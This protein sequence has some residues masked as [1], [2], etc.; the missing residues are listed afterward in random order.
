MSISSSLSTVDGDDECIVLSF[1]S[2]A[3]GLDIGLEQVGLSV[4]LCCEN[5]VD[6]AA[7]IRDNK[8]HIP[9]LGDACS[10]DAEQVLHAASIDNSDRVF[11]V[12]G[13]PPCQ[14]FST[15]GKRKALN[16]VR[17]N[18]LLAFVSLAL[19]I[20]PRYVL[21]ENVRGL[22]FA[23]RGLVLQQVADAFE[24]RGYGVAFNLY[25]AANFGVPQRRERVILIASRDGSRVPSLVPTHDE[26]ARYGL[27]R[28]TTFRQCCGEHSDDETD[29]EHVNFSEERLRFFRML[30]SGQNWRSLPTPELQQLALGN[31]NRSS[32]GTTGYVR[33]LAWD[34]PSHTL[35]THPAMRSTSLAHPVHNR[36]LSIG[37]YAILQQFPTD[38]RISGSLLARY[39]Q[40]GNA[41]P[42][43]LGRAAGLALLRHCGMIRDDK[44][45]PTN[46]C[47]SRYRNTDYQSWRDKRNLI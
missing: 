21:I 12:C 8:P 33:R 37:E 46:F 38:Y 22:L 36:P 16:D 4:R 35:V 28:W 6:A 14:S 42:V 40:L 9:L 30:N 2:G 31:A 11:L 43:G 47:F 45:A 19:D 10:L 34:A 13:G 7:T 25:D 26:H 41:V 18:A 44:V 3:M 39:R 27:P 32:G 15:A 5:N 24:Q 29:A 1:F 20:R 23:E 17:G